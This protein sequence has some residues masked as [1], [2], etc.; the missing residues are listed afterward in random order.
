MSFIGEAIASAAIDVLFKKL[1]STELLQ[2][3][4]RE[5]I[6]AVLKKWEKRLENIK[7]VLDDA[8]EKQLEKPEV[9]KWLSELK[10]LAYYVEDILDEFA[11]EALKRELLDEPH[12]STRNLPEHLP[13]LE[14]LS[15]SSCEQLRMSIPSL[16]KDCII[17]ISECKEV[18]W[19]V[20]CILLNPEALYDISGGVILAELSLK[21]KEIV[22]YEKPTSF[23]RK[24]ASS[25]SNFCLVFSF[26]YLIPSYQ[27]IGKS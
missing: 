5:N 8:E 4:R 21:R 12:A 24:V 20:D 1:A 22:G 13:L 27:W 3:A 6:Y 19:T 7:A 15:I 17:G 26:A 25:S 18:W 14:R 23:L 10:N 11:T 9:K 16:P 2:F